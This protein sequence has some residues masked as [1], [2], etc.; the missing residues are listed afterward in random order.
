[1]KRLKVLVSAYACEPG[2][3]SEPEVGWNVA[4]QMAK[5]HD[6]WVL[7]RSNNRSAIDARL[8]EH[9]IAHLNFVYYDLPHWASWWK[10]GGRGIQLYYYLWQIGA[11]AVA[12]SLHDRVNFDLVHHVT[13]AKY[14]APSLV[15]WLPIPFVWGPV[16]GGESSPKSFWKELSPQGRRYERLR[17]WARWLAEKD[18]LVRKT[19]RRSKLALATTEETAIRLRALGAENVRLMSQVGHDFYGGVAFSD[20]PEYSTNPLRFVSIGNLLHLKG[21]HLG[22]QA[23]A[24]SGLT[25]AEYWIIGDGPEKSRLEA[26]ANRLGVSKSVKFLGRLQRKETL[27]TLARCSALV[28]PS[29]HD[30]GGL[31]CVEAMAAKKPVICLDLGGPA[32]QVTPETGFKVAARTPEQAVQDIAVAMRTLAADSELGRA[33]GEAGHRR[34]QT[35]FSWERKGEYLRQMY[36]DAVLRAA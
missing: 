5:H 36:W 18:P 4:S 7:T 29:L 15:S 10:K 16:G 12:R 1:M 19:A 35:H 28:H 2:K 20:V 24:A 21:F 3:G 9:P 17:E 32:L 27:A 34:A 11:L 6:I 22:L 23:F 25:G 14:W 26:L 30:S 13:F 8:I 33:M 31:V